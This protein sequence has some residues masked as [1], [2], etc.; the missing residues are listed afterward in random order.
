MA[1]VVVELERW[2]RGDPDVG[3]EA[4]DDDDDE[5]MSA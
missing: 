5:C 4:E 2:F 3:L 1:S